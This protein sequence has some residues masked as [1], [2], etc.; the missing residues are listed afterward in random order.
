MESKIET[1]SAYSEL[2]HPG[3]WH[4]RN[5]F[6]GVT[7]S[8]QPAVPCRK[9]SWK[10]CGRASD[11]AMG[12]R[13]WGIS[14]LPPGASAFWLDRHFDYPFETSLAS[15]KELYHTEYIFVSG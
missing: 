7:E 1:I 4:C 5:S 11:G 9:A 8:P 15:R 6:D 3:I 10:A 2:S 12:V 14:V 13:L